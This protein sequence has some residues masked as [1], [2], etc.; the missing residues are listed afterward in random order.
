MQIIETNLDFRRNHARRDET[1]YIVIHHGASNKNETAE[2]FHVMH[3]NRGFYGLGYN[4]VIEWNG[5]IKRG[6]PE[7][8]IGAHSVPVNSKS[9]GI[10]LVGD[11]T[12]HEPATKQL[13]ALAWLVKNI[14]TRYPNLKIVRHKDT[15]AT[16]CPGHLFPWGDF[17]NELEDEEMIYK[18]VNDV[19]DWGKVIV[20]KLI[21]RKSLAGDGQGNIN[22]PEST[23]KTLVILEREGVLK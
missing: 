5:T 22:L 17:I 11:F 19:P 6:R 9:I 2:S 13:E 23:L 20:K 16:A 1:E 8:A 10:C 12:K 3:K 15:D 14:L 7:W 21:D 18:T 4:Y